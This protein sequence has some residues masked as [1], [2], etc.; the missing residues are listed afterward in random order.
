MT[1]STEVRKQLFILK[2]ALKSTTQKVYSPSPKRWKDSRSNGKRMDQSIILWS[3]GS[4]VSNLG[5][6]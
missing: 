4:L 3:L 1:R 6:L 2:K 5:D